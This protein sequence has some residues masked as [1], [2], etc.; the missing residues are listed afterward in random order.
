LKGEAANP[1]DLEETRSRFGVWLES[2]RHN[3]RAAR[4]TIALMEDL[5]RKSHRVARR[6]VALKK[7]GR[8]SDAAALLAEVLQMSET[9]QA[10]FESSLHDGLPPA[11]ER[12]QLPG[13]MTAVV[14][15]MQYPKGHLPLSG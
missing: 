1:P 10:H 5:H 12:P 13:D 11:V 8:H 4:G 7:R 15:K 9:M 2:E 3:P 14:A 6:A